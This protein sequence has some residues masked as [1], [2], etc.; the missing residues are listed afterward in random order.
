MDVILTIKIPSAKVAEGVA[1][2]LRIFPNIE[3]IPDPDAPNPGGGALGPQIPKYATTKQWVQ[4][5]IR[6]RLAKDIHRGL[7][8]LEKDAGRVYDDG[9]SEI[10]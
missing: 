6:R 4:E 7:V 1:G 10:D 5:K 9:F 8:L 3:T 2:F